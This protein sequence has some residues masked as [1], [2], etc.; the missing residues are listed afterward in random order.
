MIV[1]EL[2]KHFPARAP[3]WINAATLAVWG[4]YVLLH[5]DLFQQ[6]AFEGLRILTWFGAEPVAFWGTLALIVGMTRLIALFINGAYDRTPMVRLGT[7]LVSAFVWTQVAIGFWLNEVPSASLVM[8]SSAVVMDL[9]SAY[10]ASQDVAIAD[11]TRR[12]S[13]SGVKKGGSSRG[14]HTSVV[15]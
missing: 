4:W 2:K 7:S 5:P 8:Y 10:R 12:A 15:A 1:R 6:V 13:R 11:V 3:E 14:S 9:I